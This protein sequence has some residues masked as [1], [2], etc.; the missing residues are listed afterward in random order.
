MK[1]SMQNNSRLPGSRKKNDNLDDTPKIKEVDKV[2]IDD[3]MKK[4]RPEAN[5]TLDLNNNTFLIS[6]DFSITR[7]KFLDSQRNISIA[8]AGQTELSITD[9]SHESDD[10]D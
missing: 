6:D 1:A 9:K 10:E 5:G 8:D 4:L 3:F 2:T 7:S